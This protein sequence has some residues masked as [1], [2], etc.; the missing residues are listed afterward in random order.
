MKFE[1][2][3]DRE[4][5]ETILLESNKYENWNNILKHH[6]DVYV[7]ISQDDY[8]NDIAL[9]DE[10]ILFQFLMARGFYKNNRL[11]HL[12]EDKQ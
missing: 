9:A 5:L 3:A 7:N 2:Y 1:V 10:S 6:S 8:D 11:N 12:I 4:L